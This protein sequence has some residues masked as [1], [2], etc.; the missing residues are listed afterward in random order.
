M[1]FLPKDR[2]YKNLQNDF[3]I[4]QNDYKYL[5]TPTNPKKYV[6][7]IFKESIKNGEHAS[8]SA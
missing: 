7:C 8:F 5:Q 6:T 1:H 3:K 2:A 4:L